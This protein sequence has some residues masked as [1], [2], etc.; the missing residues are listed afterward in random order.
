MLPG[1]RI[2]EP[3]PALY[4]SLLALYLLPAALC[5][6][7]MVCGLAASAAGLAAAMACMG[8]LTG[9]RGLMMAAL[10]VVPVFAAFL[11]P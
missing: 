1:Q 6:V 9:P 2:L 5:L 7:T 4:A 8:S 10:Y 11:L 3:L